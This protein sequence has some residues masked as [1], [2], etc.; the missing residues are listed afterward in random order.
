MALLRSEARKAETMAFDVEW[1][2]DRSGSA[3]PAA[4][5]QL[6]FETGLV[7]VLSL[8]SLGPLPREVHDLLRRSSCKRFGFSVHSDLEKLELAGVKIGAVE[9]LQVR[10][11][12]KFRCEEK[13]LGLRH[14][15]TSL[16][17]YELPKDKRI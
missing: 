15:A 13:R 8:V 10:C 6:A 17:S 9:D 3:H 1:E 4:V 12:R 16:L 5:L 2:P 11:S 14:M 7:F